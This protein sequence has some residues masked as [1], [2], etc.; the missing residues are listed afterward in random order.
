[1]EK[2]VASVQLSVQQVKKRVVLYLYLRSNGQNEKKNTSRLIEHAVTQRSK[3]GRSSS[4]KSIVNS[5]RDRRT[6]TVFVFLSMRGENER[7]SVVD[8]SSSS[9]MSIVSSRSNLNRS[10][11]RLRIDDDDDGQRKRTNAPSFFSLV[12]IPHWSVFS[13]ATGC[14]ID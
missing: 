3:R 8:R 9:F 6:T 1:M 12:E 2:Q 4:L 7:K 14:L 11:L 10:L 5:N 13:G